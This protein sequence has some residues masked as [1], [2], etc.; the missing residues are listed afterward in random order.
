[1]E[2]LTEVSIPIYEENGR[3]YTLDGTEVDYEVPSDATFYKDSHGN[4]YILTK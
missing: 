1:M 4:L 2:G 3:H